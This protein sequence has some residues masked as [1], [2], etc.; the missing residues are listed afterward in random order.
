MCLIV[1]AHRCNLTTLPWRVGKTATKRLRLDLRHGLCV[2]EHARTSTTVSTTN[3][4]QTSA[5]ASL[6][7]LCRN[8][9]LTALLGLARKQRPLKL[10]YRPQDLLD[11]A[12]NVWLFCHTDN[13]GVM[14][15]FI[16]VLRLYISSS[17]ERVI[18]Q[19]SPCR[20]H[21]ARGLESSYLK[22]SAITIATTKR[23]AFGPVALLGVHSDSLGVAGVT[24][25][26]QHDFACFD[27]DQDLE[28][29]RIAQTT[30]AGLL[31]G[32]TSLL[33][34]RGLALESRKRWTM[35]MGSG[36]LNQELRSCSSSPCQFTLEPTQLLQRG[37]L[38]LH[39]CFPPST[40]VRDNQAAR[41]CSSGC[42]SR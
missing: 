10:L 30:A 36:P 8:V 39:D 27:Q 2:E 16:D 37:L 5:N 38:R 35:P 7:L 4:V 19:F 25:V 31:L 34:C 21:N 32:E 14:H 29:L 12:L 23:K 3:V 33:K 18:V 22:F 9:N 15:N 13:F 26:T 42:R 40:G 17:A 20:R 1:V 28:I 11:W 24:V 6:Q 41:H